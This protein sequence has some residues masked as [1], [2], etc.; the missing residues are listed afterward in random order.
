M[1][2]HNAPDRTPAQSFAMN[3]WAIGKVMFDLAS[4]SNSKDFTAAQAPTEDEYWNQNTGS[5]LEDFDKVPF[6]NNLLNSGLA[7][8][9]PY[10]ELMRLIQSCMEANA[11][12]RND[13]SA[14]RSET[15][16][17]LKKCLQAH[18]KNPFD[19]VHYIN[20][21]DANQ[22]AGKPTQ[23]NFLFEAGELQEVLV[24]GRNDPDD[25]DLNVD[26]DRVIKQPT[27]G[28][29]SAITRLRVD[30]AKLVAQN[31]LRDEF[32]R[33]WMRDRRL[34][35][36]RGGEFIFTDNLTH[37]PDELSED[38]SD[39][40]NGGRSNDESDDDDDSDDDNA[41]EALVINFSGHTG[42]HTLDLG[43]D[44]QPPP[45]AYEMFADFVRP[46]QP[47]EVSDA[48]MRAEWDTLPQE[49]QEVFG[50]AYEQALNYYDRYSGLYDTRPQK[51]ALQ[52]LAADKLPKNWRYMN[53][54]ARE[55]WQHENDKQR[56]RELN[57]KYKRALRAWQRRARRKNKMLEESPRFLTFLEKWHTNNGIQADQSFGSLSASSKVLELGSIWRR[58]GTQERADLRLRYARWVE[59]QLPATAEQ[60]SDRAIQQGSDR[61]EGSVDQNRASLLIPSPAD[62]PLSGFFVPGGG[63][64]QP[65]L[66]QA[67]QPTLQQQSPV[68]QEANSQDRPGSED[69]QTVNPDPQAQAQQAQ[70][71]LNQLQQMNALQPQIPQVVQ[72][73]QADPLQQP[74]VQQPTLQNVPQP[75]ALPPVPTVIV[76]PRPAGHYPTLNWPERKK[77]K[78]EAEKL[79]IQG[80]N[81]PTGKRNGRR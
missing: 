40:D 42:K 54:Q 36:E 59:R 13:L 51:Q 79:A 62:V 22:L 15:T 81:N 76:P 21:A 3:V 43:S 29:A 31:L 19:R 66:N 52:P 11:D 63:Q 48:E 34:V 17:G 23:N 2:P 12:D 7:A 47:A 74:T 8:R 27:R 70:A 78:T 5:M 58:L 9:A 64:Y 80:W 35:Q 32:R 6:K 30:Q 28:E 44:P 67:A 73:Q 25:E 24:P 68:Q 75:P 57:R 69:Q 77:K 53:V 61:Q 14:L 18:L 60:N 46:A 55:R 45:P 41:A 33:A 56:R 20:N 26:E 72:Q 50:R 37:L 16:E 49:H 1:P 38:P 39:I 10:P 71:A 4:L 65:N